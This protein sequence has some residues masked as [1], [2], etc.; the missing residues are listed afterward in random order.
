MTP[1]PFTGS[2]VQQRLT[3]L[4]E[5][6][7]TPI[8]AIKTIH[9]EFDCSLEDAKREFS[10]STAWGQEAAGADQLHADVIA[11]LEKASKT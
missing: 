3:Q 1:N 9:A 6:G 11:V 7:A 8:K 4:K 5:E 10:L 2:L